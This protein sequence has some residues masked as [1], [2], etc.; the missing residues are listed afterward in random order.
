MEIRETTEQEKETMNLKL[1]FK[2][3]DVCRLQ[4]TLMASFLHEQGRRFETE[5]TNH[6]AGVVGPY[7]PTH[8]KMAVRK[9]KATLIWVGDN[10][11]HAMIVRDWYKKIHKCEAHIIWDM[12]QCERVVWVDIPYD[13]M[14]PLRVHKRYTQE[15]IDD[16][17]TGWKPPK[18]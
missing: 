5:T 10:H 7:D 17:E 4:E 11:L 9:E 15:E 1:E 14:P 12:V 6:T 18:A 3:F 8:E 2:H 16:G 13:D